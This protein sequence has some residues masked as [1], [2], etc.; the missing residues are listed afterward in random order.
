MNKQQ[1]LKWCIDNI[2]QWPESY[3]PDTRPQGWKWIGVLDNSTETGLKVY[4]CHRSTG[5]IVTSREFYR[6]RSQ[7]AF[8][9]QSCGMSF[10]E[11]MEDLEK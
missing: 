1:A 2:P 5:Q 11:M 8:R 6:G 10:S 9:L 7:D 4:L 3:F